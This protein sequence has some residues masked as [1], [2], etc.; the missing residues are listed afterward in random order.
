MKPGRP[1]IEIT[2]QH[3]GRLVVEWPV[4][5]N[6]IKGE[7]LWL[8]VCDC[9]VLY[10]V[11]GCDLRRGHTT[12]CG[13]LARGLA[14]ERLITRNRSI[15]PNLSHGHALRSGRTAE[16]RAWIGMIQRCQNPKIKSFARYGGR[17]IS[18]CPQWLESFQNFLDDVGL[19]P[20]PKLSIDRINNDGNYEPG[21]VRWATSLEQ[22]RNRSPRNLASA[23]RVS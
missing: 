3:F 20:A 16:F 13:C 2:G 7:I 1:Q 22:A 8:C 23:T 12:S 17:G 5:R 10:I 18:V 6:G 11:S 4:G 21:N 9:G 14:R 15:P 19:K